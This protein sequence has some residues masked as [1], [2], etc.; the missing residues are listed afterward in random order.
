MP[1]IKALFGFQLIVV[2][3]QGFQDQITKPER[4]IHYCAIALTALTIVLV[5][6]PVAF[7][8]QTVPLSPT[9]GFLKWAG[10]ALGVAMAPLALA[11][12]LDLHVVGYAIVHRRALSIAV[13]ASILGACFLLWFVLPA[14]KRLQ[15][16]RES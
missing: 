15:H 11:L 7:H 3:S 16:R 13:S 12:A 6:A 9:D 5:L 8:R 14:L 1:G 10:F 4:L 2:F